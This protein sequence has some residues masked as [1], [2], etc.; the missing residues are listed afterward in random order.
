[1]KN[2]P[3]YTGARDIPLR[4]VLLSGEE[5]FDP[6]ETT[7][8]EITIIPPV[9]DKIVKPATVGVV[10]DGRPCLECILSVDD[11]SVAGRYEAIPY[12]ESAGP[13]GPAAPVSWHVFRSRR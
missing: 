3:V 4:I 13:G 10:K 5:V 7:R 6:S 11:L 12:V 1:M 2:D 8:K 9:G